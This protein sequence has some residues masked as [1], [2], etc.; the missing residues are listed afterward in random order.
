MQTRPS[1]QRNIQVRTYHMSLWQDLRYNQIHLQKPQRLDISTLRSLMLDSRKLPPVFCVL[2]QCA[3]PAEETSITLQYRHAFSTNDLRKTNTSSGSFGRTPNDDTLTE[4][5]TSIAN[6][7]CKLTVIGQSDGKIVYW[8]PRRWNQNDPK[9][10][11]DTNQLSCHEFPGHINTPIHSLCYGMC[12]IMDTKHNKHGLILSGASDSKIKI[13]DPWHRVEKSKDSPILEIDGKHN[14]TVL[15]L[16]YANYQLISGATDCTIRIWIAYTKNNDRYHLRRNLHTKR[17]KSSNVTKSDATDTRNTET[18]KPKTDLDDVQYPELQCQ[19]IIQFDSWCRCVCP[20]INNKYLMIADDRGILYAYH[21]AWSSKKIL[22]NLSSS[23]NISSPCAVEGSLSENNKVLGVRSKVKTI[24]VLDKKAAPVYTME[25]HS[26]LHRLAITFMLFVVNANYI[27]TLSSDYTMQVHDSITCAAIF[28]VK[29]PE[30]CKYTCADYN[31][32]HHELY[33]V[34]EHGMLQ[35]WDI[36]REQCLHAQQLRKS[37]L[38]QVKCSSASQISVTAPD[39]VEVW[40]IERIKR[41]KNAQGH[42]GDVISVLIIGPTPDKEQVNKPLSSL[43]NTLDCLDLSTNVAQATSATKLTPDELENNLR[44]LDTVMYS[45]GMDNTIRSWDIQTMS[46]R[47]IFDNEKESSLSEIS[48]LIHIQGSRALITGHHNGTMYWWNT[49]NA[50]NTKLPHAHTDAITKIHH[51]QRNNT[52][53]LFS[54]SQDG[55]LAVYD[56]ETMK[57]EKIFHWQKSVVLSEEYGMLSIVSNDTHCYIGS[58]N[59]KVYVYDIEMCKIDN[60]LNIGDNTNVID[61]QMD[62]NFLFVCCEFGGIAIWELTLGFEIDRL[63]VIPGN[64]NG[65]KQKCVGIYFHADSNLLV[66]VS[67]RSVIVYDYVLGAITERIHCEE[68]IAS[69]TFYNGSLFCGCKN[70]M[71]SRHRLAS[72]PNEAIAGLVRKATVGFGRFN[73]RKSRFQGVASRLKRPSVQS[74]IAKRRAMEDL[75]PVVK[76]NKGDREFSVKFNTTSLAK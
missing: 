25:Y 49:D 32:Q 44:N 4:I 59:G 8:R 76:W 1:P 5:Q 20:S 75:Q 50:S 47:G 73:R 9:C 54:I 38:L 69:F 34:D 10:K 6:E 58:A 68:H 66:I 72:F 71:I 18:N 16:Q 33:V 70:S 40:S 30:N 52:E 24:H 22:S 74:I 29:N 15:C 11:L 14:G 57:N 19:Q 37:P 61:L 36:R 26:K 62:S 41:P 60:V 13:W 51:Y 67:E 27:V 17:S 12:D 35:I 28:G 23:S 53:I 55:L 42:Q 2:Y 31:H 64:T 46:C 48:T 45:A 65:L 56:I 63:N 43:D 3:M 7:A 21:T 39:C